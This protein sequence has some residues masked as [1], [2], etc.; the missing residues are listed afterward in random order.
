MSAAAPRL[1][2]FF[3][4]RAPATVQDPFAG[5]A[6]DTHQ[7][8]CER[9]HD[10]DTRTPGRAATNLWIYERGE[11][12]A[13]TSSALAR[14]IDEPSTKEPPM[15]RPLSRFPRITPPT[16][17]PLPATF[18]VAAV[19]LFG[20]PLMGAEGDA[21][22][23]RVV[24]DVVAQAESSDAEDVG[25]DTDR[26][27][28]LDEE[29]LALGSDPANPDTDGDG[30]LDSFDP[31]VRGN[32]VV[33]SDLDGVDDA[34]EQQ[35]GSDPQNP[36]TDGDGILD[37]FDPDLWGRAAG[38]SDGDG[39]SDVDEG[40]IGTDH[41]N[42][43]TDFD[44]LSDLDELMSGATDPKNPDS[45]FDSVLDGN[46]PDSFYRADSDGDAL[47]DQD[48]AYYGTNP[49]NPDS[50]SDGLSDYQE[51]VGGM[52][53]PRNPDSD[54]D[55][56]LDGAD[57]Q[58]ASF[59]D[60]DADGLTDGDELSIGTDPYSADTD[61]DG[62]SDM[63]ELMRGVT[64]PRLADS[65][66]DGVLDSADPDTSRSNDADGDGLLDQDEQM[67]GTDALNPDT[68]FDGLSDL[69]ELMNGVTD[70]LVSDSDGD[71]LRD[72]EDEDSRDSVDSDGDGL[73]DRDEL[74]IGTDPSRTDTDGDGLSDLDEL[75]V[76]GTDPRNPDTDGD[77]VPDGQRADE[78]RPDGSR[79]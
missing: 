62:L 19:A 7:V 51:L 27:G 23:I 39:L 33:D 40:Y 29:E 10:L 11:I 77:G 18:R 71:G 28:L 53:D 34:T 56:I 67:F 1:V 32:A 31:D 5:E 22:T 41:N 59:V 61:A 49:F 78:Q 21:C 47:A 58:G 45:D 20:I 4:M 57:D 36:D 50:D 64:D 13:E 3:T 15:R 52:T 48:E 6:V 65:D 46:D 55:G 54:Y 74:A 12:C 9:E 72:G 24:G 79:G 30:L 42:P 63:E 70:P 17:L 43:D 35:V 16:S 66:G 75:T 76:T 73:H 44:G 8:M 68:D 60:S 38:D 2:G 69:E 25:V 14:E 26:D 37:G